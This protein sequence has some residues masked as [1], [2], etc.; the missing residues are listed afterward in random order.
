MIIKDLG[1]E[2]KVCD[3]CGKRFYPDGPAV[4]GSDAVI[5]T[6]FENQDPE[7]PHD[8]CSNCCDEREV[9]V[10]TGSCLRWFRRSALNDE[11]ECMWCEGERI[12]RKYDTP[13][14]VGADVTRALINTHRDFERVTFLIS[15]AIVLGITL[16][17]A[18]ELFGGE[19]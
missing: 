8:L 15:E 19:R 16:G 10:C 5:F 4:D 17:Y 14:V 7:K 6:G 11:G 1:R 12:A 2:Y 13:L 18:V 9:D 3:G